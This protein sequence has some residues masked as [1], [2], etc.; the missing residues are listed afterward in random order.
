M[1]YNA[2]EVDALKIVYVQGFMGTII[3]FFVIAYFQTV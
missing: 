2:Y 3:M 1:D